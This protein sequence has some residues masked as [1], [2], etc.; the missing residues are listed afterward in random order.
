MSKVIPVPFLALFSGPELETM[1]CGSPDIPL[2]LLKS[3]ATY[4]GISN[5]TYYDII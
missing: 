2:T 1:V 4:K 5:N 3:V